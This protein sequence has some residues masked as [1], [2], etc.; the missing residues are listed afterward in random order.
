MQFQMFLWFLAST[1]CQSRSEIMR[2]LFKFC[3]IP[4]DKLL[5]STT[6]ITL[7]KFLLYIRTAFFQNSW[8]VVFR[9]K[10]KSF[11]KMTIS[12]AKLGI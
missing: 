10:N 6:N 2:D 3:W 5:A 9:S 12:I 8:C 7:L 11:C 1:T 4:H